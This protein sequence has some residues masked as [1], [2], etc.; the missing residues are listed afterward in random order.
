MLI[1]RGSE[2]DL[3]V[4]AGHIPF[5]TS[6]VRGRCAVITPEGRKEGTIEEGILTVDKE[7][8]TVLTAALAWDGEETKADG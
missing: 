1:L 8:T 5:V 7:Q 6:V 3:A 4:M 2:G